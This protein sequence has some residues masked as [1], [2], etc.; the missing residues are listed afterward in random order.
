MK[1]SSG[2]SAPLASMSRSETSRGVSAICS[3]LS[4]PPGRGPLRSTSLP[5]CGSIRLAVSRTVTPP[6]PSPPAQSRR[7]NH[8]SPTSPLLLPSLPRLRREAQPGEPPGSPLPPP[9]GPSRR[10]LLRLRLSRAGETM[11]PPRA[12]FFSQV[13]LG[14]A[15]KLNRGNLP[16]PPCPLHVPAHAATSFA[17]GSVAQGKPC[18]PHEPPSSPKFASAPPR[19]STG[20]TSRFP[21]APSTCRLTP[22]PPSP[23]AP[24]RRGNHVS[25]PSPLL[26][27]SLP[28]L[29]RGAQPGEPPGSPLP[30]PRAGSR[31][32]LLRLRLS[33][34][35]ETMFPPRA[36][37]FSQVCLGSAEELNRGNLPVPPCP[38]HVPAH[39]A[40]SFASG[41]VAQG[42]PCF[43]PEPPS[44]PKFASAPPRSSTGGT[45]RFPLAPS[46][47]RLTP[48]PPSPPAQSR[49]GNHVS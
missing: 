22:P 16:V 10:H 37:F 43:P 39:A 9:R 7:G 2:E 3:S 33:R 44:S 8:V 35:G 24:S 47:C 42:K 40:T 31:R 49:R 12:P 46:T 11:F 28:R 27:P 26:L 23:P 4:T 32:H 21:L 25:P 41:S 1:P 48:P 13:C 6:P 20:G 17:S 29:R 14:S 19:S 5:P 30:P 18:F 34:A 38:L 36:P 45:S 15:E